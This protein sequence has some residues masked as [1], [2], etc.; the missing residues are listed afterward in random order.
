MSEGGR[1]VTTYPG[2]KLREQRVAASAPPAGLPLMSLPQR[3]MLVR[4][5]RPD[6]L[7]RQWLPLL[8]SEAAHASIEEVEA[9]ATLLLNHG[10]VSVTDRQ[11]KSGWQRQS[12]TWLHLP[13]LKGLLGLGTLESRRD[14]RSAQLQALAEWVRPHER[15]HAAAADLAAGGTALNLP[16]LARRVELL[17]ALARWQDEQHTGTRRDF[18]LLAR[19]RTK[20]LATAEWQWLDAHVDLAALGI[21]RFAQQVW[22]AGALTLHW[23]PDHGCDLWALHCVGFA[24]R[25]LLQVARASPPQ[26][27]WLIENR[28]SFERQAAQREAGVALVW[29]PGRPPGEWLS[30]VGALLDAAPAPARISADPD[31]A[32]VEIALTAGSLWEQRGLAWEPHLMG[33]EQLASTRQ[34]LPLDAHHD[35]AVL[36]RIEARPGVPDALRQLCMHMAREQVKAEQEGWL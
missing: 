18:E 35:P 21:E 2:P 33:V 10:W 4:W 22:L 31:P 9:L 1:P 29:L 15:L 8:R 13:T 19:G 12:I 34:T 28:A 25:D 20:S 30:G 24:A 3:E 6:N 11:A 7:T 17:Q 26:H 32:G 23:P 27:Y 5:A 36:A 14:E 16:T